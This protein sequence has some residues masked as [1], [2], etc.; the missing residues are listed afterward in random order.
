MQSPETA[1]AEWFDESSLPRY[2]VRRLEAASGIKIPGSGFVLKVILAYIALLVP[3]NWLICRYVLGRREYAWIVVPL[4]SLG[5][6]VGVERAA[7]Y[8]AGYNSASDEID[9]VE[10]Q[11]GYPRAHVSRFLSL[12][13][14]GRTRFDIS[15]PNEPTSL[16]LPLDNGRYLRGEDI[17]TTTWR[18][19][20]TPAL[21]GYLVQP[22]SLAFVRAEQMIGLDGSIRL[23]SD[24][25]GRRLVNESGLELRDAQIVEGDGNGGRTI[26]RLGTIAPA[27]TVPVV[28]SDGATTPPADLSKDFDPAELLKILAESHEARP[29]NNGAIRLVAWTPGTI[30]GQTIEP[31]VDRKRG[32]TAVVVHLAPGALPSPSG[33]TYDLFA[34]P[35]APPPRATPPPPPDTQPRMPGRRGLQGTRPNIDSDPIQRVIRN[36]GR[37]ETP[38]KAGR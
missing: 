28:E 17:D 30:P 5:F 24:D 36:A 14:T 10:I 33:P 11:G 15:Y 19:Y 2:C 37:E 32:F 23:E 26:T 13:S 18:S 34:R 20:P 1:V 9:V 35:P 8:D 31:A 22:R 21:E 12:F 29:E 16:A 38:E 3:I 7:A 27:A 25:N 4:L 6:A